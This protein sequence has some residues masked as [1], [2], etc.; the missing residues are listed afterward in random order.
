MTAVS[1]QAVARPLAETFRVIRCDFRGQLMTPG[2]PP[3]DVAEHADD[4][5]TLLDHLGLHSVHVVGTSF[6]GVV[7]TL[8]AARHP[9]RARSLITIASAD[10]FDDVMADEVGRW[11]QGCVEA[12]EGDDRGALSDTLEPVVY[13]PRWVAAHAAERSQR[14]TQIAA[15][16]DAWFE[17]LIG[18]LDSAHSLRLRDELVEI[19]APTLVIA[20]EL[21]GFVPL[22]RARGLANAI[23]GARFEIIEGAGHAVVVEQPQAIVDLCVAFLEDLGSS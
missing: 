20:A 10:G 3:R 23:S 8:F 21:D 12:L 2:E 13:S 18:L 1:W 11:R 22:D 5:A 14:R 6:G 4:L 7:G 16:P 15:L 17:G 9:D 19:T